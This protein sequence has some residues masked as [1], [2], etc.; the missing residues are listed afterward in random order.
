ESI[1]RALEPHALA[2]TKGH[3]TALD[4]LAAIEAALLARNHYSLEVPWSGREDPVVAF[5]REGRGGHCEYFAS[6]MALLA[7]TIGIP[8]RVVGGYR[9][10]EHNAVGGYYLVRE[11]DA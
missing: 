7:R 9:V 10:V 4:Q 11:R 3:T 2:F 5:V 6:A 8:A 1:A